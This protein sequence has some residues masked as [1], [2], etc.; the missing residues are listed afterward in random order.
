MKNFLAFSINSGQYSFVAFDS[1]NKFHFSCNGKD[2][3][4]EIVWRWKKWYMLE[5]LFYWADSFIFSFFLSLVEEISNVT[6]IFGSLL[7]CREIYWLL[8]RRILSAGWNICTFLWFI[9]FMFNKMVSIAVL[10]ALEDLTTQFHS[11]LLATPH[12]FHT[13]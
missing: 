7:G 12:Y 8:R 11:L 3:M 6:K 4:E 1:V 13:Y 5:V 9:V 2:V 10:W